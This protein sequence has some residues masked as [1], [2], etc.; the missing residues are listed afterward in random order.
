MKR[1]LVLVAALLLFAGA[2]Q[3]REFT[4]AV[5]A[6][7]TSN[8]AERYLSLV[9]EEI[10]QL[11]GDAYNVRW[12]RKPSFSARWSAQSAQSALRAALNSDADAVFCLGVLVTQA[13][14]QVNPLPK[15]VVGGAYLSGESLGLTVERDRT[16]R[17]NFV[18]SIAKGR[19]RR[20]IQALRSLF[21]SKK[22]AAVMDKAHYEGLRFV[23]EQI[24]KIESEF[25]V[26]VLPVPVLDNGL[27]AASAVPEHA[28]AVYLSSLP[29]MDEKAMDTLINALRD[30]GVPTFAMMGLPLVKRGATAGLAPFAGRQLARRAAL[31]LHDIADG[32]KPQ[33]LPVIIRLEE[34]LYI[35]KDALSDLV[36]S[37]RL[38]ALRSAEMIG[39]SRTD[40][41]KLSLDKAIAMAASRSLQGA[42]GREDVLTG[43]ADRRIAASHMLPQASAYLAYSQIDQDRAVMTRNQYPWEKTTTGVAVSQ[44]LFNDDVITAYRRAGRSVEGRRLLEK[45]ARLDSMRDGGLAYVNCLAAKALY[46]I[47]AENLSLTRSLL[48][49]AK[50]RRDSGVSGPED[51]Y[52]WEAA[53]AGSRQMLIAREAGVSNAL[54]NLNRALNVSLDTKWRL[55]AF[56]PRKA[57]GYLLGALASE[58]MKTPES[59]RYFVQRAQTE[60]L[61]LPAIEALEKSQEA[62]Q[63]L[64]ARKER[65][66]F[67]PSLGA[68]FSYDHEIDKTQIGA[69]RIQ[70][71]DPFEDSFDLG[72]KASLPLLQGGAMVAETAKARAGLR[73]LAV[74]RQQAEQQAQTRARII[75]YNAS[76]SY[77]AIDL[78][79]LGVDRARRNL[80]VIRDRY[81]HGAV[82]VISLLD[83]RNELLTWQRQSVSA[84]YGYLK[85]MI[86]LQHALG[87]FASGRPQVER[88]EFLGSLVK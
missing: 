62:Q 6:D 31:N 79:V 24:R 75:A 28:D 1:C 48:E 51:V 87:W 53:E 73:K 50:V 29:R 27:A 26:E 40:G 20:D 44:M 5:A 7:G 13:A 52:R 80:S 72:V 68:S 14:L 33:E 83:A 21:P 37:P 63:I 55:D 70:D 23:P 3:A 25:G 41:K 39:S 8:R 2:A 32:A 30:R 78:A 19:V 60:A 43:E 17:R 77:P 4:I 45:S 86:E 46:D 56:S 42:M 85:D 66:H 49:M 81:R 16:S 22:I 10:Q 34:R 38:D 76:Q 74:Q 82:G 18:L 47:E 67:V 15:P 11:S 65:S 58:V 12:M 36:V 9:K 54:A 84:V 35:N 61:R 71:P 88:E 57:R 64:V 69:T 59:L